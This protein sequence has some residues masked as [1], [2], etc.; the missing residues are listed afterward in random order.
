[1]EQVENGVHFLDFLI[2][3]GP[4]TSRNAIK[5]LEIKGYPKNKVQEAL[6]FSKKL[7]FKA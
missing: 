6:E 1:M 2:N 4:C 5:L 7:S 3:Q